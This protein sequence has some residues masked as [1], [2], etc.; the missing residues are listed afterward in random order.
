MEILLGNAAPKAKD[1]TLVD[2]L[3]GPS[4]CRVV[5]PDHRSWNPSINPDEFKAHLYHSVLNREG[6]VTTRP[7]DEALLDVVH[8][9]GLWRA[10]SLD[11]S[12]LWVA[13][14]RSD[15]DEAFAKIVADYYGIPY[16]LPSDVEQLYHTASG[17]PG[18]GPFSPA[19]I[20]AKQIENLLVNSGRD[21]WARLEGG[22][23]SV[24]LT[25]TATA[26]TANTLTVAGLTASAW[27]NAVLIT[28]TAWGVIVSNTTGAFT[29]DRWYSYTTPGG[30]AAATPSGTTTFVVMWGPTPAMFMGLSTVTTAPASGDT[31]MASEIVNGT[32][33]GENNVIGTLPTGLLRAITTYAHSAGTNTFTQ[34]ITYTVNSNESGILPVTIG[35]MGLFWSIISTVAAMAFETLLSPTTATLSAVGDQLTVTETVTGS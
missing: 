9:G 13:G 26:T 23:G 1:G 2:G 30:A 27:I 33:A 6:G 21:W 5:I 12:P 10:Q 34:T 16:G 4:V 29:I 17:G 31:T 11:A 14:A 35:R 3:E 15:T 7:E 32:P 20:A 18:V 19:V 22:N 8:P 24:G 25:G 28:P